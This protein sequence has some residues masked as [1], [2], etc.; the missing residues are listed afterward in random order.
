MSFIIIF[1]ILPKDLKIY[2]I[3]VGQGDSTLIV[4]PRNKT[5]LID[6]GGSTS[7]EFDVG[8]KTLLPYLLD[9]G[10]TKLDYIMISHFDQDH[11]G[12]LLTIMQKIKVKNVIIGKQ[13]E[14]CENYEK[15]IN[16]VKENKINVKVVELGKRVNIEKNIYI[17]ILW[18][19]S[20]NMISDN[21]INNNSLVCKLVYKN[22]SIL[23]TG[24]IE[25]I[26]EE[27]ILEEVNNKLLRTDILK[28]AHHGSKTSSTEKFLEA[29]NPKIALIGVGENNK[30]GH[31]NDG[32]IE[33]LKKCGVSIYR[34][35]LNREITISTNGE[36]YKF[37]TLN[38]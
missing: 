37:D 32:V 23:F 12:G 35:D 11:V 1:N 17:D 16:I 4:T 13:Y 34:T 24:D 22:F 25:E 10:I 21:A 18:P 6:G 36:K 9:R 8:E 29:V 30:F 28:I 19:S 15:F 31:P 20:K 7:S 38:K 14:F 5:I 26:A 3:D 2:F 33:R 27:K